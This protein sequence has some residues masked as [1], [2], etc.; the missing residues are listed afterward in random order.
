MADRTM[1]DEQALDQIA[2]GL[3]LHATDPGNN[4]VE[5]LLYDITSYV[6]QTG[7]STD[8]PEGA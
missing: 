5:A 4:P 8:T 1:T 2:A 3:G 6:K 7:R